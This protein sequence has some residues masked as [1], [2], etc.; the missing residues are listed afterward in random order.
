[1]SIT[2][3]N[4]TQV[5]LKIKDYYVWDPEKNLGYYGALEYSILPGGDKTIQSSVFTAKLLAQMKPQEIHVKS[6]ENTLQLLP[7][8]VFESNKGKDVI[9][10]MGGDGVLGARFVSRGEIAI[11]GRTG[12]KTIAQRIWGMLPFRGAVADIEIPVA[13]AV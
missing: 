2:A 3:H 4:K 7:D 6:G 13:D 8:E 1:M 11:A 9:F 5:L 10:E 12:G